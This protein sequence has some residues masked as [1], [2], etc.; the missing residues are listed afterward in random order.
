MSF[1]CVD[2]GKLQCMTSSKLHCENVVCDLHFALMKSGQLMHSMGRY[3]KVL[4]GFACAVKG[5]C[6]FFGTEGYCDLTKDSE[7]TNIRTE[8]VCGRQHE[9]EAMYI[10]RTSDYLQW[11]CPVCRAAVPYSR[12][13]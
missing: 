13:P 1:N 7:F 5:C 3:F 10:Q 2:G 6:R 12:E 4:D 8:P 11:V 9:P